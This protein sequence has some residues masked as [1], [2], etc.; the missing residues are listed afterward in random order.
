MQ[1]TK[2]ITVNQKTTALSSQKIISNSSK[3][4]GFHSTSSAYLT[5]ATMMLNISTNL[6]V[7]QINKQLSTLQEGLVLQVAN[8]TQHY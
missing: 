6:S 7:N 1:P 5:H 3:R 2:K 4:E 8:L